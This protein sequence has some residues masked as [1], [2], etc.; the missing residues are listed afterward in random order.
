LGSALHQAGA[1]VMLNVRVVPSAP[2]TMVKGMYGDRLKISVAAPPEAD[3][4]NQELTKALAKW[5]DVPRNSVRLDVGH[6]SRDKAVVFTGVEERELRRR[7]NGLLNLDGRP[8]ERQ[9][10]G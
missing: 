1:G 7:L 4:A 2:R 5:L 9:Q 10:G 8:K 3:R 6:K